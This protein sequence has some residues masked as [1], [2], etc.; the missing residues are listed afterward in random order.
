MTFLLAGSSWEQADHTTVAS[1]GTCPFWSLGR[2]ER[3]NESVKIFQ[4]WFALG[5][6]INRWQQNVFS[7][8]V[9]QIHLLIQIFQNYCISTLLQNLLQETQLEKGILCYWLF[10]LAICKVSSFP[11]VY[12]SLP[13]S[14]FRVNSIRPKEKLRMPYRK[15]QLSSHLCILIAK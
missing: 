4:L 8:L 1:G 12:G 5:C 9:K 6:L 10:F 13:V 7:N 11:K 2:A 3:G 14:C 15:M